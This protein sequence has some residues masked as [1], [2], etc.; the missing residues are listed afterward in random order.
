MKVIILKPSKYP[1]NRASRMSTLCGF[2]PAGSWDPLVCLQKPKR[3]SM[4][5]FFVWFWFFFLHFTDDWYV[6]KFWGLESAF[7]VNGFKKEKQLSSVLK[8]QSCIE[9]MEKTFPSKLWAQAAESQHSQNS[10]NQ[11]QA[12]QTGPP[13][14]NQTHKRLTEP[15]GKTLQGKTNKPYRGSFRNNHVVLTG[16]WCSVELSSILNSKTGTGTDPRRCSPPSW[17]SVPSS[18]SRRAEKRGLQ[19]VRGVCWGGGC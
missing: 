15:P 16:C 5:F 14:T 8:V 11:S 17:S 9:A 10:Q 12:A 2:L 1:N 6:V 18:W 19:E 4:C 7:W 13:R 3:I